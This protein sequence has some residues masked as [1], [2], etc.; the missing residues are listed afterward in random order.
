MNIVEEFINQNEQPLNQLTEENPQLGSAIIEALA[1]ISF[2]A[3]NNNVKFDEEKKTQLLSSLEVE[4]PKAEE[5]PQGVL[6][7]IDSIVAEN[8]PS[9]SEPTPTET[10][11]EMKWVI[12]SSSINDNYQVSN[13]LAKEAKKL[14]IKNEF[15]LLPSGKV[16]LVMDKPLSLKEGA[17]QWA[18]NLV[19]SQIQMT[20]E[21]ID[22][23]VQ[24][25]TSTA[26]ETHTATTPIVH[27]S[28]EFVEDDILVSQED[29]DALKQLEDLED[30][31][32]INIDDLDI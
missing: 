22:Q 6:E 32:D 31:K 23:L 19:E 28:K 5:T 3:T 17:Q 15:F 1:V 14:G 25:N 21:Q 12:E 11:E 16:I 8:Q 24:G 26:P 2:Y 13:V 27:T 18:K 4:K 20:D 30:L 7:K 29:L 10:T 9:V